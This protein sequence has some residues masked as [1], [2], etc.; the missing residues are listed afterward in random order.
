MW[1]M[2]GYPKDPSVLNNCSV[3]QEKGRLP[4]ILRPYWRITVSH[5][6]SSPWTY[7][8]EYV[9]DIL[10]LSLTCTSEFVIFWLSFTFHWFD[11]R[12]YSEYTSDKVSSVRE[13]NSSELGQSAVFVL[14][15][16]PWQLMVEKPELFHRQGSLMNK[17]LWTHVYSRP[18]LMY[19]ARSQECKQNWTKACQSK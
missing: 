1:G 18:S 7:G 14:M 16:T 4:I 11:A 13:P 10:N 2:Y 6:I 8:A 5:A 17:R 3:S 15:L 19:R 9:V 12:R